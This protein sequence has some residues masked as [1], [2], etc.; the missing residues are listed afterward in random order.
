MKITPVLLLLLIFFVCAETASACARV[1]FGVPPCAYWTRAD[2]V[3]L[4][5][6][7]KVEAASKTEDLP[8]GVRKIRFQVLEN[9]KGAD[10]P[11]FS[12]VAADA[13]TDGGLS[14]KAGQT[15]IIY[16]ANDIVVKSFSAFRTVKIEPKQPSE[17]LETLKAVVAGKTLTGISGRL[18]SADQ[19]GRYVYEAVEII[20]E[21][22]GKKFS[23]RTDADGAFNIPVP[24]GSY[25][26]ELKFPYHASFKWDENLLG[27]SLTQGVPTVF[28]YEVRLNDGDCNFN[29]FEVFKKTP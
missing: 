5:K 14:I 10:N 17:E 19:N 16:A 25:R 28:K 7:L 15:W 4:G 3:F 22:G 26:V 8:E 13:K 18:A 12:L 24:D 23:A 2:A 20:V 21:G 27:T 6:V 29:F 1:E 9:F 11:T